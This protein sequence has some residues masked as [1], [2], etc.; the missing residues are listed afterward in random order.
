MLRRPITGTNRAKT[1]SSFRPGVGAA[2]ADGLA[3]AVFL[4][5]PK[6]R[7]RGTHASVVPRHFCLARQRVLQIPS[8]VNDFAAGRRQ[9]RREC[10]SV[11]ALGVFRKVMPCR[12]SDGASLSQEDRSMKKIFSLAILALPLAIGSAH[13]S[14]WPYNFQCGGSF[15]FAGSNGRG[16]Q[17]GPWYL[18][19]PLEAHFVAPAPTGYPYWP[20]P[21]ALPPTTFGGPAVPPPPVFAP[22]PPVPAVPPA[23]VAPP[24][25][26]TAPAP[27]T[28][29]PQPRLQLPSYLQPTSYYIPVSTGQPPSYWYDR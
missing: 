20:S 6:H 3:S 10:L 27:P 23:P 7:L 13:A 29:P 19:W 18:Y 17:A 21:Q 15:Y 5:R 16:P 24:P 28:Q 14:G 1:D 9:R 22:P 26:T 8:L 11:R 25:V 12:W 4:L 2:L